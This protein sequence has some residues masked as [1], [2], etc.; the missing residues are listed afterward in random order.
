MAADGA[1]SVR[2]VEE[3]VPSREEERVQVHKRLRHI[4]QNLDREYQE[5]CC[6]Q[7]L[8]VSAEQRIMPKY[9]VNPLKFP[10]II[11]VGRPHSQ[12]ERDTIIGPRNLDWWNS[13]RSLILHCDGRL[14]KEDMGVMCSILS[15]MEDFIRKA[16]RSTLSEQDSTLWFIYNK[17]S[18]IKNIGLTVSQV[19]DKFIKDSKF[20]R[21]NIRD[22]RRV[23]NIR[24]GDEYVYHHSDIDESSIDSL[25]SRE[26]DVDSND[27]EYV[28]IGEVIET[29]W[30]KPR[31]DDYD[32]RAHKFST[33][34]YG[35]R[36]DWRGIKI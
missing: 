35:R 29:N 5:Q 10:G 22:V 20:S 14:R 11:G 3:W 26:E 27:T 25:E 30:V 2:G 23:W 16:T 34:L 7:H 19:L 18:E 28:T 6:P 24:E 4:D 13:P 31:G 36:K 15:R 8:N 1:T 17:I 21:E 12:Q 32:E 9:P 33:E